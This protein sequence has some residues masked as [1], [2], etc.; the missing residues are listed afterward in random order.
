MPSSNLYRHQHILGIYVHPKPNKYKNQS[1]LKS[2][3]TQAFSILSLLVLLGSRFYIEFYQF[4]LW[5]S[6]FTPGILSG[7]LHCI[8]PSRPLGPLYCQAVSVVLVF[9]S[10]WSRTV[11]GQ[12]FCGMP[13]VCLIIL[14]FDSGDR[15]WWRVYRREGWQES[16]WPVPGD[17][18][19]HCVVKRVWVSSP[20][21]KVSL[22]FPYFIR[23]A[24]LEG[25]ASSSVLVSEILL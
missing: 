14:R 7:T 2:Q 18:D 17:A 1:P 10:S 23:K 15:F 9:M 25:R 3:P 24:P 4:F 6:M 19:F 5:Q 21:W 16:P 8:W 13:T 22:P 12:V 20:H 11:T